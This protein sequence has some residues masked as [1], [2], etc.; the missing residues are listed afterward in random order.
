M[1]QLQL[2]SKLLPRSAPPQAYA[3]ALFYSAKK[4]DGLP[5]RKA[6]EQKV[7]ASVKMALVD[8]AQTLIPRFKYLKKKI[9]HIQMAKATQLY[10]LIYQLVWEDKRCTLALRV[11]NLTRRKQ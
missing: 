10:L 5:C 6:S 9:T 3:I 1:K 7:I 2:L 8:F 11:T 4:V